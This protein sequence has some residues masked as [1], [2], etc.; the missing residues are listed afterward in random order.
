MNYKTT[1]LTFT[2][3][4]N[5]GDNYRM[6]ECVEQIAQ[7]I[8]QYFGTAIED[9]TRINDLV[10]QEIVASWRRERNSQVEVNGGSK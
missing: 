4:L 7:L 5:G 6:N 3:P 2:I 10:D 9:V 8:D 1:E